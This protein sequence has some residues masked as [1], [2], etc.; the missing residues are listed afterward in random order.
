MAKHKLVLSFG[1]LVFLSGGI[2]MAQVTTGTISGTVRDSTG[3]VLP[4]AKVVVLNEE[5]GISRTVETDTAGRYS[6]PGLSLGN[7]RVT[8]TLEGFQT[9]VRSG[10]VLTV[11]R[12]AIVDLALTVG[13]VNQTVE[14]MGEAP[15][16]E[17][18]S[19]SLG[20]LVDDRTIRALPLNGR[21]YD[22]LAL[23]QPG[24]ILSD[25]G[26]GSGTPFKSGSGKRF[27]VGGQR[28]TSNSFLLDGTNIN[29]QANG[30][31]GG[32][33]GT[34]L[35]VDTI[36][37]FKIFTNSFKAEYGHSDGSVVSAITRSGTNS[38][39]G[40]AFEYLR[41]SALDA[42]NFFDVGSS[43]PSFK[44]NQ[45]GGVLGGPIK[46]DKTFFFGG[47]EGLRQALATTQIATVPT[48]AARQGILPSGT[49]PV[50]PSSVP[51]VNLYPLPNGRDFGD[52]TAEYLSSPSIV[53]NEDN[54][55]V[56]VDH[57]L[58]A[59]TGI[60]GRYTYDN[61]DQNAPL[62]L[63]PFA[64]IT[65]AR[66]QYATLQANSILGP[67]V[68]NNFRFAFNRTYTNWNPVSIA[69]GPLSI[70][71]G[72]PLGGIALGGLISGAK[73]PIT[74]LGAN[75]TGDGPSIF[76]Y[77]VFQWGDD[78][79]YVAGKHSLKTGVDIQR[80]WDNTPQG[81]QQRGNY[82]FT[83]FSDLLAGK[84]AN[85]GA[86]VPVGLTQY[87]A[88]RQNV[89]GVYGQD[90]YAVNS[91]LTLN[92]G[93]RW[94]TATDPYDVN[95]RTALLPSPAATNTVLSDQ[96]FSIG[97]RNFEPRFGLAWQL[98]ASGKTVLRAGGGI[99]HNQILPWLYPTQLKV[100]PFFAQAKVSNPP[101]PNGYQVLTGGGSI[102]LKA[103]DP[104]EKTPVTDQYNVS[105]QQELFRNTV[106]QVSFA[107]NKANHLE[108]GREADT[109][110]PTILPNGQPF[111]PAGAPRRNT[112]WNGILLSATN[113]NSVYNSLTVT[114][115]K[116]TSSGFVGQIFYTFSKAMD[117]ST[118][119]NTSDSQR[120]PTDT[121]DPANL[122]RDWSLA[123]F[124]SRHAVVFN[125]SY[126]IPFRAG[127][128]AL[129]AVVNG[130]TINGI[131]TFTAGLPFTAR[132]AASVSRDLAG[133]LVERPNLKP[134]ASQNPNHGTSTGCAGFPAGAKLGGA[135]NFYDPCS[136]ALPLAG[137]YGNLGRDTIIGPG[138]RDVD[139]ALEKNFKLHEEANVTFKAEVFNI[140]NHAN[141]GLPN[142]LPL[143]TT[144]AA[145]AS[146]GR[147]TYTTTSSRQIQFALRISF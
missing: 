93:L 57:Q 13:A 115:R 120:A 146:A 109:P 45:F 135:D 103:M 37:E 113:A 118:P 132:L 77:S 49:V 42:R 64:I 100:P 7:Y 128:K 58:N 22:Q 110:I 97:K 31:P 51:Y 60:F 78:F 101:F 3:A 2:I 96:F 6:A 71:P 139:L 40:T 5:T 122:G 130:W 121:L 18:T 4:G 32:A 56:R 74:S 144:G 24:V 23:L 86:S 129:G 102:A 35:G 26:Q 12:E 124:D 143:D 134:G 75:T 119:T 14:V 30:T 36:L 55:M 61:D 140:M 94:E 141:F 53:T 87:W 47:Y 99:Y 48:R 25:P 41:N 125:F 136:F 8:G 50:N 28:P 70:I 21:S 127:S 95:G 62:S 92:L 19:A 59:K 123:E 98:T 69:P 117:N 15:L 108:T 38:L 106:L 54:F 67:K 105:I 43:P 65:A 116:Q 88:I 11:G 34:N 133:S 1:L 137:T 145:S 131:G 147:I 16:V 142:S 79:S 82:T 68:L 9:Q 84:A 80:I 126:P 39:H 107:G 104:I 46:K 17:S 89:F 76:A 66:R 44:R 10:I 112:A 27:S 91:R 111:Y 73:R 20:S 81:N 85:L 33:A 63:P 29:D 90:D 83:T 138:V 114:L 52:G 72:Q